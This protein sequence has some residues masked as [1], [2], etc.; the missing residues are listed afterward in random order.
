MRLLVRLNA[1]TDAAWDNACHHKIRGRI[2]QALRGTRWEAFHDIPEPMGLSYTLPFPWGDLSEGETRNLLIASP[3]PDMLAHINAS[4]LDDPEFNI[5]EIPFD[6]ADVSPLDPDVG[7]AGSTG[8]LETMT[9]A[10]CQIPAHKR[11]EYGIEVV[12]DVDGTPTFWRP[13]HTFEPFITQIK[14]NAL[15]KHRLFVEGEHPGLATDGGV[16]LEENRRSEDDLHLFDGW[17]FQN[18]F[19]IP[20]NVTTNEQHPFVLSKWEFPY[21]VQDEAHREMLNLL[22]DT[23]IGG[24]NAYGFGFMNR[25]SEGGQ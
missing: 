14:K 19:S 15:R 21:T 16:V 12:D 9:G 11:E 5:G 7:A 20:V 1:Q 22:L 23:G 25:Q 6:V 24:K 18:D 2:W 4:L 17:D 10:L 3:H 8:T 13:E